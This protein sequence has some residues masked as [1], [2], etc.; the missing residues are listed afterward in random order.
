MM[1]GSLFRL[2]ETINK[3]RG[4]GLDYSTR[5]AM[6]DIE[7]LREYIV[8]AREAGIDR[9]PPEPQLSEELGVT[10]GRLRTLLKYMERDGLIWRHVGKGTFIGSR[11]PKPPATTASP[12]VS[13][14]DIIQARMVLEPPLAA[15]AAIHST[16]ADLEAM[17]ACMQKMK[18][19]RDFKE[20]IRLDAELHNLIVTASHNALLLRL[21]E[22]LRSEMALHLDS[23]LRAVFN[24]PPGEAPMHE[25]ESEHAAMVN[26]IR[27]HDPRQAE[28]LMLEHIKSVRR[29]LFGNL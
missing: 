17:D 25:T 8:S 26:A 27:S 3:V 11:Q 21:Y 22:T 16:A 23:R 29:K 28:S 5:N 9:L 19:T 4:S 12:Y 10:R 7:R 14:D 20:W 1:H 18:S 13:G 24:A 2:P 15:L 6:K